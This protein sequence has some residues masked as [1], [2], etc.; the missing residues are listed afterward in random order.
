M[1]KTGDR[2]Y[3]FFKSK[4]NSVN[5]EW[6]PASV[7]KEKEHYVDCRRFTHGR[8]MRLACEH[9]RLINSDGRTRDIKYTYL[10]EEISGMN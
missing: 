2:I 4:N 9:I 6:I 5:I 3:V 1:I 8:S 10:E 7:I